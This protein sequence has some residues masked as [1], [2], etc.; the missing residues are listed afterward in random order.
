MIWS[1]NYWWL[2][3]TDNLSNLDSQKNFSSSSYSLSLKVKNL[4]TIL[5]KRCYSTNSIHQAL[6][7]VDSI[8]NNE[9]IKFAS[10]EDACKQI[11][12][13]FIGVS[14]VYKLTSKNNSSRFYIGSSSNLAR[15]MEEYNK[16]TKGLRNPHSASELEISKNSALDWSLEFIY[17]TTPQTS[18]VFEQYAILKF[19]PTI[20]SNYNVTPR[21]NPQWGN[22]PS[23][24]QGRRSPRED[25]A[26]L[27]VEKL[28]S[29][30][31]KDS[32]GYSRLAVFLKTLK[33]ANSLTFDSDDLDSKYYCFLIFV[34]DVNLPSKDPIVY[35]SINR[36]MQGL[37][38]SYSSLL[39]YINNKYL[40]KSSIILS[41]EP[42]SVE[43]FSEY[44]EKPT[45]DN[46][47]RKHIVVFNQDNEVII[48][49]KS[50]RE[51]ANYFKID[52]KVARAAIAQGEYQDFLL[53][54]R[55]VSY[56]KAIYVFDSNSHKLLA[57]LKSVTKAMKYAKV[58][59]YTLKSLI[60]SGN[61]HD[62][63]IYS[64]KDK[65]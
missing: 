29:L 65:L 50:G 49:F 52:G 58:N 31:S 4:A 15:R 35:S 64:Y 47:L 39:S 11:K 1:T 22:L 28:L 44:A 2:I 32:V 54:S 33:T 43:N 38:I 30:F 45:G 46:Q 57:E 13:K 18:L 10:L 8:D 48:E 19:K 56:R 36:A 41:F 59:F 23:D 40:Y 6:C 63:K 17:F 12:Y 55:E 61:S 51:M 42:L 5:P 60:E 7:D 14:G 53:I 9:S 62:G 21:V 34:Y 20:N 16:L 26:I 3:S 27:T 37:Q 24:P 25:N